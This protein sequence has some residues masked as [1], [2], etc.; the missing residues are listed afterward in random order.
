MR[1]KRKRTLRRFPEKKKELDTY[2][3]NTGKGRKVPE[4]KEQPIVDIPYGG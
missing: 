3:Q 1:G 2:P 4:S